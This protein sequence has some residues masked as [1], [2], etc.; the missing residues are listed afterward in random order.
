MKLS[1]FKGI[2]NYDFDFDE[3]KDSMDRLMGSVSMFNAKLVANGYQRM[4]K[5]EYIKFMEYMKVHPIYNY[6]QYIVI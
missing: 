5:F 1:N 3:D 2:I 6:N 4:G